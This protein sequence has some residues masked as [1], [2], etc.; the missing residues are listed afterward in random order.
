MTTPDDIAR[1]IITEGQ[2][3][4]T[5]GTPETLHGVITPRGIQIALATALV[6]TNEQN[7]ANPADPDSENFPN[8]GQGYD[9]LS[10]GVMQQQPPWWGTVTERMT[11]A[12]AAAMFYNH[13]ERLSYNDPNISPGTFAQDVQRSAF[14]DRYDQRFGDAVAQYTRLVGQVNPVSAPA[15]NEVNQ[16]GKCPNW[17][18]RNGTPI[19]LWIIHTQEGN[20]NAFDL[21]NFLD[22]TAGGSNPV[23]YH[24][25][26]DNSVNVVDV[27][28]TDNACWAVGSANDRSINLCFAGST[29]NWSRQE[30]L[31]NMG[32][33]IDVAAYLCVQDCR[34]YGITMNVLAPPYSAPPPGITDHKYVTQYL[35]WGTHIDV[36][37]NF[38]WDV[39]S[40][41]ITKYANGDGFLMALTDQQ[42]Q[43]LYDKIMAY[44]EDPSIAG[45]WQSR[46]MFADTAA[47]IDDTVGILL[48][49]DG[50][51]WNGVNILGALLGVD[52]CVR[53]VQRMA[54]GNFPAGSYVAGNTWL[55]GIAKDF[56]T[57]LLPLCGALSSLA[58]KAA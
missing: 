20:G 23:S 43:A 28:D 33:A 41:S 58:P 36:G 47:G 5:A 32:N 53:Q 46:S 44:P 17:E 3:A 16:L 21:A 34:K 39:F 24:Y 10:D 51:G 52:Y 38:P 42:Q 30:W 48:N 14:P 12:L 13:L 8:D 7:L 2:A 19:D 1:A 31:D 11:P 4:R 55:Q 45:K 9:H 35:G 29:V 37:N 50:N 6:E 22:S 26:I 25:T 40:A 54:K 18:S 15:Y 49:S 57:K 27:V 56:A